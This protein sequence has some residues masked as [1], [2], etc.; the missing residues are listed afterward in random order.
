MISPHLP[1][2]TEKCAGKNMKPTEETGCTHLVNLELPLD[3]L[4]EEGKIQQLPSGFQACP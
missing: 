3:L 4:R 1:R 2:H